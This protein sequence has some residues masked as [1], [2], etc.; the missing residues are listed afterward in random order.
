MWKKISV[1]MIRRTRANYPIF[2]AQRN[3]P[4]CIFIN[5]KCFQYVFIAT[6]CDQV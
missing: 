1:A 5:W 6:Y 3:D 2:V 4:I